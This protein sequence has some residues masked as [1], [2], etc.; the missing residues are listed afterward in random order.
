[1]IYKDFSSTKQKRY[2]FYLF[3][4]VGALFFVSLQFPM[5]AETPIASESLLKKK[6][7]KRDYPSLEEG[8]LSLKR[9]PLRLKIPDISSQVE[10]LLRKTRPDVGQ[11]ENEAVILLK[12]SHEERGFCFNEPIFMHFDSKENLRFSNDLKKFWVTPLLNSD[13]SI[14]ISIGFDED[15]L[16][17]K[18][19]RVPDFNI[20]PKIPS[21]SSAATLQNS[22][23]FRS[24]SAAKWWGKDQF[25]KIY[26]KGKPLYERLELEDHPLLGVLPEYLL[27]WKKDH[28]ELLDDLEKTQ[29]K[30]IAKIKP[31]ENKE[32][33]IEGWDKNGDYYLFKIQP[34]PSSALKSSMETLLSNI[35]MRTLTQVT[36]NIGKEHLTMKV[37][38]WAAKMNG[39]W[40]V[41]KSPEDF[42]EFEASA[43]SSE[44]FVF[45]GIKKIANKK[46]LLGHHFN[47]MRTE[48][49]QVKQ[50]LGPSKFHKHSSSAENQT[51]PRKERTKKNLSKFSKKHKAKT[52]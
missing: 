19:K 8:L 22:A 41:L 51:Q 3:S 49:A 37:G 24:L 45:D 17:I 39:I 11:P 32:L 7:K 52:Q 13:N 21:Y 29:N 30:I 48:C 42:E 18:P 47:P 1:M 46:T 12:N 27:V 6:T 4:L 5:L 38:D 31:L 43:K 14:T 23:P 20:L 26:Q 25:T 9:A 44:L 40:K 50:P 10:I 35:R 15:S 2:L 36:L 33:E 28:W 16:P 34:S